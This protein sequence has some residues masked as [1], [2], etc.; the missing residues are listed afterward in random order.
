MFSQNCMF[1][2]TKSK[3]S[4]LS[5]NC[6]KQLFATCLQTPTYSKKLAKNNKHNCALWGGFPSK[7]YPVCKYI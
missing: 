6:L 1:A 2:K 3:I 7:S 5:M 4:A